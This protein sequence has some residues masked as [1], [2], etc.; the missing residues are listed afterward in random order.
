MKKYKIDDTYESR[1]RFFF[2]LS[3]ILYNVYKDSKDMDSWTAR[4]FI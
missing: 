2:I 1:F 3:I 4:M